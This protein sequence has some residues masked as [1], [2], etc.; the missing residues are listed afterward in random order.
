MITQRKKLVSIILAMSLSIMVLTLSTSAAGSKPY[1]GVTIRFLRH[2]GYEADWMQSK[3]PEFE[4]ETGIH[5]IMDTISYSNMHSK[6]IIELSAG[7][8]AHDIYAIPDYWVGEYA[9]PGWLASISK[10]MKDPKLYDKSFEVDDIPSSLLELNSVRGNILV[11]PY[12][13]NTRLLFYRT[14]LLKNAGLAVPKTWDEMLAAANALTTDGRFGVDLS[15][16]MANLCDLFRDFLESAGGKMFTKTNKP[17]FNSPAGVQAV[18][19]MKSLLKYAPA[20]SLMRQWPDSANLMEQDKIA[21]GILIPNFAGELSDPKKSLVVGKIGYAQIPAKV[22]SKTYVSSWGLGIAAKSANPQA[23]YLFIQWLLSR[24][25]MKDLTIS[26]DGGIV[27]SRASVLSDQ[28]IL[29]KYPQMIAAR[30][31][32][33]NA[34]MWETITAIEQCKEIVARNVQQA[35]TGTTSSKGALDQAAKEITQLLKESGDIK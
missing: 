13:Y 6:Q 25:R 7:T 31:A 12:K 28:E 35:L 14:D 2:S 30:D 9:K 4:K 3:L 23:A 29:A 24:Q 5:V 21:L 33:K 34:W 18:E 11:L 26:T 8:G 19:F 20:G 32:A 27:P 15:A 22:T 17:A 16:H 1:A 10:L